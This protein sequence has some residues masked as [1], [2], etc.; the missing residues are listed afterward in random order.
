[1]FCL[2]ILYDNLLFLFSSTY[3]LYLLFVYASQSSLW[4]L[5]LSRSRF[6]LAYFILARSFEYIVLN[7]FFKRKFAFKSFRFFI[8]KQKKTIKSL[9]KVIITRLFDYLCHLSQSNKRLG[10]FSTMLTFEQ[11]QLSHTYTFRSTY[12]A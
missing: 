4:T 5:I 6:T 10:S 9:P 1:M 3:S 7:K 11:D 8:L 2:F 12:F